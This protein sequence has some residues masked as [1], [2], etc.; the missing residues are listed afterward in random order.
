MS[1]VTT[2]INIL[3]QLLCKDKLGWDNQ[4]SNDI[5]IIWNELLSEIIQ[6]ETLVF[7]RFVSV[8]SVEKIEFVEIHGF[9][10]KRILLYY[11]SVP[12]LLLGLKFL[13]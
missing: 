7:K 2:K 4:I 3:F 1:P 9:C 5:E 8:Q 6:L 12:K 13:Y 10:D 11:I